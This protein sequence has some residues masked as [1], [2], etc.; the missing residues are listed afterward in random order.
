MDMSCAPE[1]M[2]ARGKKKSGKTRRG[3]DYPE[4]DTDGVR[5]GAIVDQ[6]DCF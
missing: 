2:R 1:T 5:M 4:S 3:N 6:R